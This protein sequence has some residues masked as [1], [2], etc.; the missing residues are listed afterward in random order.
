M[1]TFKLLQLLHEQNIRVFNKDGNLQVKAPKG[2]MTKEILVALKANKQA[3][4]DYLEE[5]QQQTLEMDV[6]DRK[7]PHPL[8]YAQQRLWF[9]DQM[10]D[11][12]SHYNSTVVLQVSGD[13]DVKAAEL[14]FSNIIQRHEIL[15][16]VYIKGQ[17]GP[18]QKVKAFE[19]F[20]L[21]VIDIQALSEV[22]QQERIKQLIAQETHY[23][24]RLT[25]DLMMRV[26]YVCTGLK[27]GL[28]LFNI[29]HI[30]SDGWSHGI[31]IKE[32]VALYDAYIHHRTPEL[33]PLPLQYIDYAQWQR[34]WFNDKGQ[35]LHLDYWIKQ[36]NNLPQVHELPIDYERPKMQSFKGA[37]HS[38]IIG[39]ELSTAL[40]ALALDH[41]VT[42]FM[43]L[44]SVFSVLI[45][46]YSNTTDVVIGTPV[47]NRQHETLEPLIGCFI[48]TLVLR[49]DC[50]DN[51]AF[52]DFL[53]QVKRIN[54]DAQSH[55]DVPFEQV[56]D[57]LKPD[58]DTSYHPL[59]QVMFSMDTNEKPAM[60]LSGVELVIQ[61]QDDLMVKFDLILNAINDKDQG[62]ICDFQF[63]TDLFSPSTIANFTQ[64]FTRIL[65]AISVD[66]NQR[67]AELPLLS[68]QQKQYLIHGL[69]D[70]HK[71]YDTAICIQQQF[72]QQVL[73][74]PHAIAVVGDQEIT[75]QQLNK[76]ANQL[77]HHLMSCEVDIDDVVGICLPRTEALLVAILA[78][79]KAGGAYLP[80]DPIYPIK[81]LNHMIE[82]SG[83]SLI[84]TNTALC[85]LT[86]EVGCS[87]WLIDDA[88][89][90]EALHRMP[91]EN[92]LIAGVHSENLA[93]VI[94][95][96]GSTG[97]P[98]G[99]MVSHRSVINLAEN[100]L[101][102]TAPLKK[103]LW[104]WVAPV[105]F[106]A[107]VQGLC[108]LIHGTG[109]Q[110]ISTEQKTDECSMRG[111][112]S[113]RSLSVM[114]CTPSL[115]DVWFK[116][117]LAEDL[118]HLF[119]GGES[120]SVELW[121][122]LVHWQS[123]NGTQAFNVYGPTEACVNS[124]LTAITGDQTHIGRPLNNVMCYVLDE[125]RQVVPQDTPGELYIGGAGLARGYIN[126][127]ALSNERFV[128]VELDQH[129]TL[130]LYKTGDL[131]RYLPDGALLF[132]ERMD[133][134]VKIRGYR[135][136][137]GEI[138]HHIVEH[139]C[140]DH[141]VVTVVED[142]HCSKH[143]VAYLTHH[144]SIQQEQ[145][146]SKLKQTLVLHVPEYMV[147]SYFIVLQELP[148]TANGKVDYRSL[149]RNFTESDDEQV[150]VAPTTEV[151]RTLCN[152]WA[153]LL[154]K[155]P[156]TVS[157]TDN[158]FALGGDS[159]L[160]IQVVSRAVQAG[161]KVTV[162]QIFEHQSIQRLS[163]HVQINAQQISQKAV[164]GMMPLMPIQAQ[165]FTDERALDHFNQGVIFKVPS[166]FNRDFLQQCLL[167]LYKRHDALRLRFEK[168][169]GQWQARYE[170]INQQMIDDSLVEISVN[171]AEY[172]DFAD[173][174]NVHQ[175]SL[176]ISD[177]PL[178]KAVYCHEGQSEDE[179]EDEGQARLLLIIHHLVV[180]G[181]S[182]RILIDDLEL[183]LK[184]YRAGESLSLP[185]KTSSYQSWSEYLVSFGQSAALLLQQSYWSKLLSQPLIDL[186]GQQMI[187]QHRDAKVFKRKALTIESDITEQLL[188]SAPA[189]YNTHIN[190]LLLSALLLAFYQTTGETNLR[191][192]LE[193]HGRQ[194]L[195]DEIDLS[196]TVGWFTA[197]FPLQLHSESMDIESV[198]CAIKKL[199]RSIPDNGIGFGLLKYINPCFPDTL[200]APIL[201]N[202]MGQFADQEVEGKCFHL[203]DE[204]IGDS[205]SPD[206]GL[207]HDIN[208]NGSVMAAELSFV[209][210]YNASIYDEETIH[211]FMAHFKS[212][213]EQII[214]HCIDPEN[215]HLTPEDFPLAQ[216][217]Q[218]QL[219]SWQTQHEIADIY[220]ATAM[221]QGLLFHSEL[222][223]S[224]YVTQLMFT[225]GADVDIQDFRQAW[226]Q[227]MDRH[228]ILRTIFITDDQGHTQQVVLQQMQLPW[229]EQDLSD[230]EQDKQNQVI[231]QYRLKDKAS[232]FALDQGPLLRFAVW[233]LGDKGYRVLFSNHHSII[234][235]W[236]MPVIY[237][238]VIQ[239]YQANV[240]G[241]KATLKSVVDYKGYVEWLQSQD[242]EKAEAFW[243]HY[244][245]GAQYALPIFEKG[246]DAEG[247][248]TEQISLD[249]HHT[250]LLKNAAK[251]MNVTVN[252]VLQGLWSYILYRYT[253]QKNV[254][255]GTTI[256]GRP[257]ELSGI[258]NMVGLF[259]NTIPISIHIDPTMSLSTWLKDIHDQQN[260]RDQ[261][262]F[263]PLA[264]IQKQCIRDDAR[265]LF[266]SLFVFE[267]Y[268]DMNS[269]KDISVTDIQSY[270]QTNYPL[271]IVIVL[272]QQLDIGFTGKCNHFSAQ[273]LQQLVKHFEYLLNYFIKTPEQRIEQ[274]DIWSSEQ[275]TAFVKSLNKTVK[276]YSQEQSI[277]ELFNQKV[278]SIPK[279]IAIIHNAN[280][281]SYKQ[282]NDRSNQLAHYL[283]DQG[284]GPQ[285]LIGVIMNRSVDMIVSILAVFKIRGAYV[286]MDPIY[287]QE[288]LNYM[289]QDS[290]V[291]YILTHHKHEQKVLSDA[292]IIVLD[293]TSIAQQVLY[294]EADLPDVGT[295]EPTDLAYV[296][297]TSGSTGHPKGVSIEQ[298]SLLNLCQWHI[299][300][301]NVNSQT[302]ASHLASIGFD[303]AVWEIWPY[304]VSGSKI[305]VIDDDMRINAH[306]LL[307]CLADKKVTHCYLP[308][309]LL[310]SITTELNANQ[311]LS[312]KYVLTGGE[313]LSFVQLNNVQL[314][315]HYGPTEATVVSSSYTVRNDEQPP[316]GKGISNV[317]LLVLSPERQLVPKGCLGEL[318]IGGI[319]VAR[320]Y[321]NQRQLTQE[322][323]IDDPF[324]F[325]QRL[326]KSGDLVRYRS[327]GELM[328]IGRV[329]DQVKIRGFRIELGEI[330]AQLQNQK[331]IKD[332]FVVF[333]KEGGDTEGRLVAYVTVNDELD[334]ESL[335]QDLSASL[336]EYMV[337]QIY[338]ELEA[339]PLT[340][341][342]K[343]NRKALPNPESYLSQ[344]EYVTPQTETEVI[345]SEIWQDLL[346][347]E[348]VSRHDNFFKLGGHS[349][350]AVRLVSLVQKRLERSLSLQTLFEEPILKDLSKAMNDTKQSELSPIALA[351]RTQPLPLS[352]AQQRLWFIAQLAGGNA[353]YHIPGAVQLQGELSRG[354]LEKTF[355]TIITRHESLRTVFKDVDG[356]VWQE[357]VT[358]EIFNFN[359]E[360]KDLS[361]INEQHNELTIEADAFN[362]R[363]FDLTTGPLIRAMLVQLSEH[364]HVLLV[365]MHHIVS[366]GWSM[367]I[368]VREFNALYEAYRLDQSDPLSVLP[369]QY[370][371]YAVWQRTELGDD[372]L[373][374]QGDYWTEHL[375]DIPQLLSLPT[376]H[377]RPAKPSYRGGVVD[378]QLDAQLSKQIRALAL[379]QGMTVHM[380]LHAV[381][382]VLLSRLSGQDQ[383]VVGTPVANRRR[384]EVNNLIGF[385]VN[386][387]ALRVDLS[388]ALSV[389]EVLSQVKAITLDGYAN[390]DVPFEQV[391]ELVQPERSLRYSPVFQT[392]FNFEQN[393]TE[394]ELNL[395]GLTA[396]VMTLDSEEVEK[397]DLTLSLVE[398]KNMAGA[399]NDGIVGSLTY[400]HDLFDQQTIQRWSVYFS[401]LVAAFVNDIEAPVYELS[402]L[403]K[404][405]R[406]HLL[407][408]LNQT[409]ADYP[410]SALIHG[411]FEG[412]VKDNPDAI[413]VVFEGENLSYKEL[414]QR[415]NQLAHY[416]IEQGVKPDTLVG[417]C[418][419]RSIEMVIGLMGILKAGGAY[420]PL[421]PTY[422]E[423]R[424][425]YQ[426]TDA[427]LDIVVTQASLQDLMISAKP[428]NTVFLDSEEILECLQS[429]SKCNVNVK[430][431]GL[432]TEN[433]AYVIYTSGTTGKPKGVMIEHRNTVAMLSWAL[434]AY[435]VSELKGVLAS[436][437]V[438]FD[439]SVYEIFVSLSSGGCAYVVKDILDL[440]LMENAD[441]L[442][443]INTVPSAIEALMAI[444]SLPPT[445]RTINLAGEA[446]KQQTVDKLYH[447]GVNKVYDLYGPSEDTTYSTYVL[448]ELNGQP[449]I[450]QPIH[451]SQ[452]YI[453]DSHMNLCPF[454]VPGELLIGGAGLTRGYLNHQE[455]TDEKYLANPFYDFDGQKSKRLY[456]T[457][458]LVRWLPNGN[459]EYLGRIDHQVKLRGFR[460]ELGEIEAQL[461]NQESVRDAVVVLDADR[462]V[463]YIVAIDGSD[464]DNDLLFQALKTSLPEYMVPQI[465]IE[466]ETL[467]LTANGK[468]DR[469]ALPK[470][471]DEHM[472]HA[473]YEAPQSEAEIKLAELWQ[474]LLNVEQVGKH[475]NF[476]TLGG[477]SLLTMRLLSQIRNTF[478]GE[479]S[480]RQIFE[481]PNLQQ[482]AQNIQTSMTNIRPA[483]ELYE[484]KN[485][486]A[487]SS[488][489]QQRLWFIDQME[490]GSSH[491]NMPSAMRIYGDFKADVAE[492][493]FAEIINR[494]ETL[495]TVFINSE[496]IPLQLIIEDFDFSIKRIDLSHLSP[497][498]QECTLQ[499][500]I[501]RDANKVFDLTE[502]LMIRVSYYQL[503]SDT[504]VLL[505]NMHHI[506]SDGW[507]M[508]ILVDE[509]C[510]LY[511]ALLQ[512]LSIDLPPLSIQYADYAHWQRQ[513]LT[514]DVLEAQLQY[515]QQ[516]LSN[517]P[518][519][520]SL[521]LDYERPEEQGY[522]GGIHHTHMEH[523]T[524]KRLDA[525]AASHGMSL[526]ML[527]HGAFSLVLSRYSN[528]TNIVVGTPVANRLDKAVE[529]LIG[530]FVNTLVLRTDCSGD[531]RVTDYLTQIKNIHVDAQ[532]HQDVP[533]EY[534]VDRLQPQR[535]TRHNALF[536]IMINMIT[537][538]A[539]EMA[540][541]N[542]TLE[543]LSGENTVCKFDIELSI[544]HD[545]KELSLVWAYK[546]DLFKPAT[547]ENFSQSLLNILDAILL[548]SHQCIG[549]LP[550]L[551]GSQYHYL[552]HTLN[553]NRCEY[554]QD[555]CIH[556]LIEK[557][558]KK[559]PDN[560]AVVCKNES[561]TYTEL[562]QQANQLAHYLLEHGVKPDDFVGLCVDRS[563]EMMVGVLA[564]LKAG[565]AY[566]PL[567]PSYPEQRMTHMLNDSRVNVL[568]TQSPLLD[569]LPIEQDRVICIDEM[570]QFSAYPVGNIDKNKIDLGSNHLAYIIYTSGSTGLPKGAAV[571]HRNET[572]L[573]YW[574]QK[575]Y[576]INSADKVLIMSAIGFDLTQ[577]NLF[578]PLVC[579]ASVQFATTRYFDVNKI[580]EFIETQGITMT[581]CAPSVFYPLVE[582]Q[583]HINQLSSLRCVLFGGEAIVFDRLKAWLQ[584]PRDHH[585]QLINMYGP[586]E[587]TD[588][589]CAYDI[590]ID[591]ELPSHAPIGS[592]NDNVELYVLNKHQQL[593]PFG[594]AGE[595]C[596]GGLGVSRGYLHQQELT[597]E[598]FI[599][600]PFNNSDGKKIYRTGDM[601]RWIKDEHGDAQLLFIGRIDN[602]IKIRGFRVELGEIESVI[603]SHE[604]IK[605]SVVLYDEVSQQLH[606]YVVVNDGVDTSDLGDFVKE[607]LPDHMRPYDFM[608]LDA[609]PLNTHGKIDKTALL[610]APMKPLDV[611]LASSYRQ[612]EGPIE[613]GL[614]EIWANLLDI[615]ASAISA[616]ANFFEMGGHSLLLTTMLHRI[617]EQW[618]KQLS[619]K[620]IFHAPTIVAIAEKINKDKQAI[621]PLQKQSDGYEGGLPLSYGQY[622]VWFIEQIRPGTNEHNMAVASHIAGDFQVDVL[623]KALNF[624]IEQHDI[625]R[626]RIAVDD[627][628]PKQ[629]VET[630]YQYEIEVIDLTDL[631]DADQ[632]QEITKLGARQDQN[633]FDLSQLPL[634]SV[635]LMKVR[636]DSYVLHFNQ[637]HIISD[638]WSQQL[639]YS[640]L[641]KYY[642]LFS[643]QDIPQIDDK[644]FSYGDYALWQKQWL[645][646]DDAEHQRQYWSGYLLDCQQQLVLPIQNHDG[647][648][649]SDQNSAQ[650][651]MPLSL[652]QKLKQLAHANKG[653]LFNALHSAFV[654]L[655]A[656]LSGQNDFNLGLPVTGRHI[657]GTQDILGMFLNTLPVRH[658]L[659][660]SQ[661]FL[662]LLREQIENVEQVLSHQD[663]PLE[664]IFE[665][666]QCDRSAESTPLFQIFFNMLSVPEDSIDYDELPFN[667]SGHETADVANKFNITLYI[668]D[669]VNGLYV[670]CHYNSSLF[671]AESIE[672]LLDQYM[673]LLQQIAQNVNKSCYSYSLNIGQHAINYDRA[674]P[675]LKKSVQDVTARFRAQ[676]A[677]QPD[678]IAI[679]DEYFDWSYQQLQHYS[680]QLAIELRAMGVQRGGVVVI[681]AERQA[682]LVAAILAILQLGAA[683]SIVTEKMPASKIVQ[684][685]EILEAKQLLLCLSTDDYDEQLL[686]NINRVADIKELSN[687]PNHYQ[688][689]NEQFSFETDLLNDIACITFT[690]G[691][692]GVPKA[693]A[694]TFL[695]LS[696]YLNWL[697]NHAEFGCDDRFSLLSGLAHDPLQR[698]IF[699]ALCTGATLVVPSKADYTSLTLSGWLKEQSLSILHL[700]PAMAEIICMHCD[701]DLS[702]V[703][704]VFLTG[705]LL[706]KDTV[707]ALLKLNPDMTVFNCYGATETQRAASYYRMTNIDDV[708]PVVPV[709]LNTDDTR[710]R[711]LNEAGQ[712][713]AI[714]EIGQICIESDRIARGYLNDESQ[715]T[716]QFIDINDGLRRYM[717]GDLGVSIDGEHVKYMGR[718]DAQIN[719]R[720]F[721]IELG[722]IEY[723]LSQHAQVNRCTTVIQDEQF[724]IAYITKEPD[725]VIANEEFKASCFAYA[726]KHLIEYM[727][728]N[729][730]V[731]LDEMPLTSNGKIDKKSLPQVD[732]SEVHD[733]CAPESETE[734]QVTE[735]WSG[736]LNLPVDKISAKAN[737]FELGGHSLLLMKLITE[738]RAIFSLELNLKWLFETKDLR[739][740]AEI[741]D[742]L[743]ERQRVTTKLDSL[744]EDEIDEIGF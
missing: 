742:A 90:Q 77:A 618:H 265:E 735:I 494:H 599:A 15:R 271:T 264:N 495:R 452:A 281:I 270:E 178:L 540:I 534:L 119:I 63:N 140:V 107:S 510:Q 164:E 628:I 45:S 468:V 167:A 485:N 605:Q 422:P 598:K 211:A 259:I 262:S 191:I 334:Q 734:C 526:F 205:I 402:M 110:I 524:L 364:D 583:N 124:T 200:P 325:G 350:L 567:D 393:D 72:E 641:M 620:D 418:L 291:S 123:E 145:L 725:V 380:V 212:S 456:K 630:S 651:H 47:A 684:Q 195:S 545:K 712:S 681:M 597:A 30:A 355:M 593:L 480:I 359:L 438:C 220:P 421:D 154:N 2:A 316:I 642:Q 109:L 158:F 689:K 721:R 664:Q 703:R 105:A 232:G 411:L 39:Q 492:K 52:S 737:F 327:D 389:R 69:N 3:L 182:W 621:S 537:T 289:I 696:G 75:Y 644:A 93:Y 315:N 16:T 172:D 700:T 101:S 568:L 576:N 97:L 679:N 321:L 558:V 604:A 662:G 429:Y 625:L 488:Y 181:V 366:D 623:Q 23:T 285:D 523:H 351:D 710:L 221:Q 609:L 83:V 449:S 238:N 443:L 113:K 64:S 66:A 719:I 333:D 322:H 135:I 67:I 471:G 476:F 733:Y 553:D 296:I 453:V 413:A 108:S 487:L 461:I 176:S 477:H 592:A 146:L 581:N 512:G 282:L 541:S 310:K 237:A 603:Q 245:Q 622:R 521:P 18:L 600:H 481:E 11:Q 501:A 250:N 163:P 373:I 276:A 655:L 459:I 663:L 128:D 574:Y 148:L 147:P 116:I 536:Q 572:N 230:H 431:Q 570:Q 607:Q 554:L 332:A 360:Y 695:G 544:H 273:S 542:V 668:K 214:K 218:Q 228:A 210:D 189:A 711:V 4:I 439:L 106:D 697:P 55:Q 70:N 466:L 426:I 376:D 274:L 430:E 702:Q 38:F 606:A 594:V 188:S 546:T 92:P 317:R 25:S 741:I 236:S 500:S 656:R 690:S 586:T 693:V 287:P 298:Q 704:V 219:T 201:F 409:Q 161:L 473:Q 61:A 676:A 215:G 608:Q 117:G 329:D 13:F 377:P 314:V 50:S 46:R 235:G 141:C 261:Y 736:L 193:G 362:Q 450:G 169:E 705:E 318:Y 382:S 538:E 40:N 636:T 268:P 304:M 611:M 267:N 157:I 278:K 342:G 457:G 555:I 400:A 36:L 144:E 87:R 247:E 152:I 143:I 520:H 513:Y 717:T 654:L 444:D 84:I 111:V 688:H 390:Q 640:Q 256:S 535:S 738:V 624:M 378:I 170:P 198:I 266:D 532:T 203:S 515:W 685:L 474:D 496:D 339:M 579:G 8:S 22:Q 96:S 348:Q 478:H 242:T 356:E 652:S 302:K 414:N 306:A 647:Q 589:S 28:L 484:R 614:T 9:I 410:D 263:L 19:G 76:R 529:P 587:C 483:I 398:I 626:T 448:R 253:G 397:F 516:Q 174:A 204:D 252:V 672:I 714:G 458:D 65:E 361:H 666:A 284:L 470:P 374:Q 185:A 582:H 297:Y 722:E 460:I 686:H 37:S 239:Y 440:A 365:T 73:K 53:A 730:I 231:E 197:M 227:T 59:F 295:N 446:L 584:Q 639:F 727:Q 207:D 20:N 435:D 680:S 323:F 739:A 118:P 277:I 403:P 401:R 683:Y 202:Y 283:L 514:G 300:K 508:G 650:I 68:E 1:T 617:V 27:T 240:N 519:V 590:P 381:W 190:E 127:P 648:L 234:D 80:L 472:A 132:I 383:I 225:L 186:N 91:V 619:V 275:Q 667:I 269:D 130:K 415:S 729:T 548:D 41:D 427:D 260:Q 682:N 305:V 94:Y 179:D 320:G 645:E 85:A 517:V 290:G 26:S 552:T 326:Y 613:S 249:D 706:R 330:E 311:A 454:G 131:V 125:N 129:T 559:T 580:C 303:A 601:V 564:I 229:N 324:I 32:W 634:F 14:A 213:L 286:P 255:F 479:L 708:P 112:L 5:S 709:N 489:A 312:L 657:Y 486:Q 533:F 335:R 569:N 387:L 420:V 136:E 363:P 707:A 10:E 670:N 629:V 74:T 153:E 187:K 340:T 331:M 254:V 150:Y 347:V 699:G 595:L 658:Q 379:S 192:D 217:T 649:N 166:D 35:E 99:V 404:A 21:N 551:T 344:V 531:Q 543:P 575:H 469:K 691:S 104:G 434:N 616:D 244:L 43:L 313:Q 627:N 549:A 425:T 345:L 346:H 588:I 160:S 7:V 447:A 180:D 209:V 173:R 358:P 596:I 114:D 631:D 462:L 723:H 646:S 155:A 184:Q 724:I 550:L 406:Q 246:Y 527:L 692:S 33:P 694:G 121:Q 208:F 562:N 528:N 88:M 525:L 671:T 416:L 206:R 216:I 51:P 467:P 319:S 175:S 475:D 502:D 539:Q 498:Q 602:Q 585:L 632:Q 455:L 465:Y 280:L 177:G 243:Q 226:Q 120:I 677:Q 159:I 369:I 272:D 490:G 635:L 726:Q 463:A 493:A 419:N 6:V 165:F 134:Q 661:S 248:I 391:V 522:N 223:H 405:E 556:E 511:E 720:G 162:K 577:K 60:N 86:D 58:R 89:V 196:Q 395:S 563:L 370:A 675:S 308:T 505:F 133:E 354:A 715:S 137:L 507:S 384:H 385:F 151:E 301:Y 336:P 504:G 615:E 718:A 388:K 12:S 445:V 139:P 368:L 34:Q 643:T 294:C 698:D 518:V 138:Q 168:N 31:L 337:P 423:A 142:D 328:F 612:P 424:L 122:R 81:R 659:D 678:K 633:S 669:D 183:L 573:L 95:T 660:L 292:Q 713:C 98:K 665:C 432:T 102:I 674:L 482:M 82:D 126:N 408:D 503:G 57:A 437:S 156:D 71:D 638:G 352:W 497:E 571:E 371:D 54:L 451:N 673:T 547:I 566:L 241:E 293:D 743:S 341:N 731:V 171:K 433:L 224:A 530:F 338:I 222:D 428:F 464:L 728:P 396:R 279:N 251:E 199:H 744:D 149:P 24:Y 560:I 732:F 578:A 561:L 357:F 740:L 367:G 233:S 687:D 441:Q 115:L 309:A 392:M 299:E 78:I 565:G 399:E 417:L 557:Q 48:N 610:D 394:G 194:E 407:V 258:E 49:I 637:H 307:S 103:G 100:I 716:K 353:A 288:R 701:A 591:G 62:L 436:T 509:F 499:Q 372:V 506:A 42:V 653:S 17:Q 257:A 56:V 375:A 349:L 386:T 442:T 44:H 79:H 491:Y 343:V 29:H 412:Q